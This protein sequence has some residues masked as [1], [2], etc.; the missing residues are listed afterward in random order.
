MNCPHCGKSNDSDSQFCSYCG[1]S[2]ENKEISTSKESV[3][4]FK[5]SKNKKIIFLGIISII[6]VI[7]ILFVSGTFAQT[8]HITCGFDD[9]S[10]FL[11]FKLITVDNEKVIS[12]EQL[13][14]VIYKNKSVV[15]NKTLNSSAD[16]WFYAEY[17]IPEGIIYRYDVEYNGSLFYEPTF[18]GSP[19]FKYD[20]PSKSNNDWFNTV[21]VNDD[22]LVSFEECVD[23]FNDLTG[24]TPPDLTESFD[25]DDVNGDGYISPS[26]WGNSV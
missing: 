8:T 6:A 26:E 18:S 23:F 9:N 10:H 17:Y 24:Y 1:E 7:G 15:F 25:H 21:D 4:I 2:L 19:Q 13:D 12:G 14:V 5:K 20:N 22:N 16:G 3:S 11:K